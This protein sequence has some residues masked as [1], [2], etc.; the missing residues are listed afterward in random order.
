MAGRLPEIVARSYRDPYYDGVDRQFRGFGGLG[1]DA[2]RRRARRRSPR[3]STASTPGRARTSRWRASRSRR[4]S[5][6]RAALSI[7]R[8][9]SRWLRRPR[10]WG[11]TASRAIFPAQ[12]ARRVTLVEGDAGVPGVFQARQIF[13][14][15]GQR[16]PSAGTTAASIGA[17]LDPEASVSTFAYA[18]DEAP[19]ILGLLAQAAP[20][21]RL[22]RAGLRGAALL[23]RPGV[24]GPGLAACSGLEISR[25]A[26]SGWRARA[27]STSSAIS[28]TRSAT[29]SASW[30]QRGGGG[31]STTTRFAT[32]FRSRSVASPSSALSCSSASRWPRPRATRAL[33]RPRR[34]A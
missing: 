32:S 24:H 4:P 2:P 3:S 13:D 25:G 16:D 12:L 6:T 1:G 11:S 27:T 30:M 9:S 23:R 17:G 10:R 14:G 26:A 22:G 15:H 5:R 20:D 19:W 33:R 8:R 34:P 29:W 21:R 18:E 31:R 28:G 7:G